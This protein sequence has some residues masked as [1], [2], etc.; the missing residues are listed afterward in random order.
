MQEM[1]TI[2]KAQGLSNEDAHLATH[3]FVK[4]KINFVHLMMV[5]ELGY[6]RL[7]PLK[8]REALLYV[9]LPI[10]CFK[11]LSLT[12][13]LLPLLYRPDASSSHSVAGLVKSANTASQNIEMTQF[14]TTETATTTVI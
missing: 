2:Y 5:E 4:N 12:L 7:E 14:G 6:S 13:P 3:I 8:R 1:I 9:G 10:L 11:T